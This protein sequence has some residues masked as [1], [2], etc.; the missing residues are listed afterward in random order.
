[1]NLS[2]PGG[3]EQQPENYGSHRGEGQKR[4]RQKGQEREETE[5]AGQESKKGEEAQEEGQRGLFK[6]LAHC[7]FSNR[8]L[9]DGAIRSI[10]VTP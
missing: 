5:E 9:A 3:R 1:M 6:Q 7:L 8:R 2:L 10:Q 4:E